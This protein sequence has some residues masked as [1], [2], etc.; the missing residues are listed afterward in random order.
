MGRTG[1]QKRAKIGFDYVH[2]LID[3]HCRLAYS[4]ILPDEKGPTCAAFLLRAA[5]YF[6]SF[7]ITRIERVMTD[8]H[9]SYKLSTC[10]LARVLQHSTTPLSHRR[11]SPDQP[12]AINVSAEY[13]QASTGG[14]PSRRSGA[15]RSVRWG[16]WSAPQHAKRTPARTTAAAPEKF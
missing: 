5:A 3:D 9:F 2:S 11:P 10:P 4:E 12:T 1:P 15:R 14:I 16:R 7:G 13:I 6:G 8:N